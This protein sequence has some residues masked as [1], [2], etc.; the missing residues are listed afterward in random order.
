VVAATERVVVWGAVV[1]T[2][3]VVAMGDRAATGAGIGS[4][5]EPMMPAARIKATANPTHS[6]TFFRR[7]IFGLGI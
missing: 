1:A 2:C 4:T 3:A 5:I 7:R 6:S